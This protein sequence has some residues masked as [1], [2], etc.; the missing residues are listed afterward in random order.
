MNSILSEQEKQFFKYLPSPLCVMEVNDNQFR[1]IALS[2]G[3]CNYL[4]I[5]YKEMPV[6]IRNFNN[7]RD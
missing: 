3:L 2:E 7:R 1:L 6:L 4:D 5:D